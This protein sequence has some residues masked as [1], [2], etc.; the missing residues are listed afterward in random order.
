MRITR[1]LLGKWVCI[2]SCLPMVACGTIAPDIQEIWGDST[3]ATLR[4]EELVRLVRCETGIAIQR[5]FRGDDSAELPGNP[6][7]DMSWFED[8]GVAVTL[9]LAVIENTALNPGVTTNKILENAVTKF[10]VNGPVTTAQNFTLAI[11]GTF[12]STATRNDTVHLFYTVKELR[13]AFFAKNKDGSYQECTRPSTGGSLFGENNFKIYEW[14]T[15][16]LLLQQ[17][18]VGNYR[19]AGLG[20]QGQNGISHE[21]KFEIVTNGNITP[22]WKLVS[23]TAN[24]GNSPLF[25]LG[26]DRTQDLIIT[27]GPIAQQKGQPPQLATAAQNT[28]LAQQI[29]FYV[30]QAIQH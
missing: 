21:V 2:I 18:Q 3:Q 8:W 13:K 1:S 4:E 6:K 28:Q 29:G 19:E 9:T 24:S 11:G 30:A 22:T 5:V 23:V 14:L 27:M 26:R 15:S 20:Q 16:N 7:R 25:G 10:P 17:V 12:S